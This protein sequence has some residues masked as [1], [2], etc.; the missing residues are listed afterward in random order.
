MTNEIT[1]YTLTV[2][3]RCSAAKKRLDANGVSYS[4]VNLDEHPDKAE[5][6]KAQGIMAAPI[7]TVG[8]HTYS[9]MTSILDFCK[10]FS[11]A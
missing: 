2:C 9:T 7:L 5:Q 6:F 8:E 11:R 4:V 1:L 3:P 10:S